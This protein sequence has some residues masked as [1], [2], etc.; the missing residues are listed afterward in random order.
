MDQPGL[1][2]DAV[3]TWLFESLV[4]PVLFAAGGMHLVE[5]A[6]LGTELALVGALQIVVMLAVLR[7]LE[8]L[9]ARL[10]DGFVTCP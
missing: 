1:W 6:F 2:F 9:T 10:A 4:Q 5:E 7:P 8:A 3:H